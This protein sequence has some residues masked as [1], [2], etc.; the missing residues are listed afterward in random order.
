MP[1][2]IITVDSNGAKLAGALITPEHGT[3]ER[4]VVM[5]GGSGPSDRN[6]DSYFPLIRPGL[7]AAG[8]A[9]LSYDKR[10]VGDSTG[11]WLDATLDDLAT[12]AI[13]AV[14][15][16]RAQGVDSVGLFGHSEGGWVVL[17]TAAR[18]DVSWAVAN[19]CPG[20]TPAAQ[21]RF[22][23]SNWLRDQG[24]SENDVDRAAKH[25][26]RVVEAGRRGVGFADIQAV[27][28]EVDDP[29]DLWSDLDEPAWE[30]LKRKQ[31]HDPLP[32]L[33]ATR[34]PI[35]A[36]Y[37]AADR[38]VPVRESI[39][40]F[41]G[42]ACEPDRNPQATFEVAIFPQANHRV[43]TETGSLADGYLQTLI[44]WMTSHSQADRRPITW[45]AV[46]R[47]RGNR[48]TRSA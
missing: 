18:T 6:N 33:R 16:L 22:G 42:V 17:C 5:V 12:D 7:V 37:G 10:G 24:A 46:R 31:D 4:G 23:T 11:N 21:D 30:F 19:S 34:C 14:D 35:L 25:Y 40:L 29:Y 38:L 3:A 15:A 44:R 48:D 45:H 1:E 9:V 20:M 41:S 27:L 32:T 43:Q 26:D 13:A 47:G 39:E 8:I 36:I 28:A 2:S